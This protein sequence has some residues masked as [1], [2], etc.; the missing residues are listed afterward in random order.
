LPVTT[1]TTSTTRPA[2]PPPT[3]AAVPPRTVN[4][5][6]APVV[7]IPTPTTAR[8][9]G[10]ADVKVRLTKVATLDQ[11]LAMAQRPGDETFYVAEKQGRIRAVRGGT[12]Q[13]EP[14]L[15]LSSEIKTG[16]EQGLL[17]ITFSPDGNFLYASFTERTNGDSRLWEYAFR[18]GKADISTRRELLYVDQPYPNH[19]GGQVTFGPDGLLYY[20]LGDGG[21]SN[22]P[23]DNAQNL[24]TLLGKMLRID[25]KASGSQPYT[26]PPDNP[27]VGRT[28]ARGEI[29]EYGLR[30]PWRWS[31]DRQTGDFWIGDVGQN[32]MEEIDYLGKAAAPGANL[33]WP[34]YEGS[35]R[36]PVKAA[37]PPPDNAVPPV[38]DYP[39]Q[40]GCA[41]TG[42]YI[43]RGSRIP[44]MQ[45]VYLFGDFCNGAVQGLRLDGGRVVEHRNLGLV[46]EQLASFGEDRDGE[47]YV[48]S[49]AGGL[50]RIDPI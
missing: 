26:I 12:V 43:Y 36:N 7:P 1:S 39:T 49:L 50:F 13:E 24:G 37:E 38:Y 6:T 45:G 35:R 23:H 42:G 21:S 15:D 8:S 18:D 30:N 40:K 20:G 19:N 3:A 25:P 46:A 29:W 22:D 48:L 4:P 16:A 5:S 14:V 44:A 31:F 32:M 27:F 33:G 34:S 28:G 41:V 9:G 17:G 47:L 2:S 10:L 11:P